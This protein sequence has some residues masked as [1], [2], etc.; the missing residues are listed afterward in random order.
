MK[1][2]YLLLALFLSCNLLTK[3]YEKRNLLQKSTSLQ[4]LKQTVKNPADWVS[5]PDYSDR[6][7]WDNQMGAF[8]D[9]QI[10]DNYGKPI[11]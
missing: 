6:A 4:R 11:W 10:K 9:I 2:L 3:G 1:K 8:K 5:Y 7:G